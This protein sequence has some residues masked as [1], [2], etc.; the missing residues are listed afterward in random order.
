MVKPISQAT[1]IAS[2]HASVE[3]RE[4]AGVIPVQWNQVTPSKTVSQFIIPGLTSAIAE[5][6]RS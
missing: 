6:A 2:L 3:P 5:L 4:T 1:R